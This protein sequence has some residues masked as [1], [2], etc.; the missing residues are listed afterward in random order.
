MVSR[1]SFCEIRLTRYEF[2]SSVLYNIDIDNMNKLIN[3]CF[4]KRL[5]RFLFWLVYVAIVCD[6]GIVTILEFDYRI[7]VPPASDNCEYRV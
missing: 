1:L 6:V 2:L 7:V 4:G 5:H 3:P